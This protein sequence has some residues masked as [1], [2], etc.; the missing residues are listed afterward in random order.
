MKPQKDRS[1]GEDIDILRAMGKHY[2]EKPDVT[3]HTLRGLDDAIEA[4]EHRWE[5]AHNWDKYP[6]PEVENDEN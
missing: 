2:S 5:V 4:L 3:I 6:V 1:L